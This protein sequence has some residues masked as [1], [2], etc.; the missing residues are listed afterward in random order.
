MNWKLSFLPDVGLVKNRGKKAK[1][2]DKVEIKIRNFIKQKKP[3][4][5]AFHSFIQT[6]S[7]QLFM[8]PILPISLV[9]TDS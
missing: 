1:G 4:L 7:S 6:Y 8:T 9:S 2:I 5:T 3:S